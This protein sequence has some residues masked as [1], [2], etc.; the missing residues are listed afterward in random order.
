M[1]K[2]FIEIFREEFR[3]VNFPIEV[4]EIRLANDPLRAVSRGCLNGAIEETRALAD[5]QKTTDVM[6]QRAEV[7][8]TSNLNE[9][10]K[11]H[12][13]KAAAPSEHEADSVKVTRID[14]PKTE[15]P[16][17]HSADREKIVAAKP[18]PKPEPIAEPSADQETILPPAPEPEN[19]VEPAPVVDQ[20]VPEESTEP[21]VHLPPADEIVVARAN[22]KKKPKRKPKED[23]GNVP[24]EDLE[25][26]SGGAEK[27]SDKNDGEVEDFPL[28][29]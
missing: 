8:K 27:T 13:K 26:V 22:P 15:A 25:S 23:N 1:P 16:A 18:A 12:I 9:N 7:S 4:K 17:E 11:R 2:G 19:E 10:T 29:S 24:E 14:V 28:F 3:K 21:E 20:E 6:I 5:I